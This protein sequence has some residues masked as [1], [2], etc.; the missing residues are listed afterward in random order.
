MIREAF[1][2]LKTAKS[3]KKKFLEVLRAP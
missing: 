3:T 2:L 1:L